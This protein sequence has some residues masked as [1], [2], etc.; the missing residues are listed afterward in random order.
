MRYFDRDMK[1]MEAETLQLHLKSC[2][3]CRDFYEDLNDIMG[4]L[5]STVP[6]APDPELETRVMLQISTLKFTGSSND[7]FSN[8]LKYGLPFVFIIFIVMGLSIVNI[9]I[10]QWIKGIL[11]YFRAITDITLILQDIFTLLSKSKVISLLFTQIQF[12]Y[13][14]V[15]FIG[16]FFIIKICAKLA[17]DPFAEE[18]GKN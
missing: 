10:F 12:F 7:G 8:I 6:I 1:D 17:T 3:S 13:V 16:A 9:S 14:A 2:Q 4:T 18:Q 11:Q 15:L 5:E